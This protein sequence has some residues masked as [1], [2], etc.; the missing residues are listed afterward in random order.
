MSLL[1]E[2]SNIFARVLGPYAETGAIL[3]KEDA[4]VELKRMFADVVD[5][6]KELQESGQ[7]VKRLIN[8]DCKSPGKGGS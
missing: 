3:D 5:A 6:C 8:V 7:D 4:A 2:R 1:F